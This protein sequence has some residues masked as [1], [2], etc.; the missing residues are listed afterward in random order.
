MA[1]RTAKKW[2]KKLINERTNDWEDDFFRDKEFLKL[3]KQ[4]KELY[5]SLLSCIQED[6]KH[7]F[8]ELDEVI[9]EILCKYEF[10]FYQYGMIDG[11]NFSEF[12]SAFKA[13]KL[14]NKSISTER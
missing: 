12:L 9:A 14:E 3:E 4:K 2:S 13:V 8:N 1:D 10:N 11:C 7:L 5:K 6:K